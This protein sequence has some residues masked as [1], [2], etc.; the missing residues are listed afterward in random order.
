MEGY[1]T[2]KVV[3]EGLRRTTGNSREISRRDL[4][5]TLEG[6]QRVD[7]GGFVVDFGANKHEGSRYVD[8]S[9]IGTDGR[10]RQ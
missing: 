5:R 7:L 10:I 8:L 1:V 2:A 6:M 9:M 4:V 3:I